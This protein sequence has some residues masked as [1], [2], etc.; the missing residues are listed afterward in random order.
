MKTFVAIIFGVLLPLSF[1]AFAEQGKDGVE[2]ENLRCESPDENN[3]GLQSYEPNIVGWNKDEH[4]D[5]HLDFKLSVKYPMRDYVSPAEGDS[6]WK[7]IYPYFAFTGR[8][9][10]YIGSQ[11]SSPVV[12]RRFN[13]ELF[14]RLWQRDGGVYKG[15]YLDVAY[16]HESN[17]QSINSEPEYDAKK[18]SLSNDRNDSRFADKFISRGWDYL[19]LT[20]KTCEPIAD[21]KKLSIYTQLRYFLDDGVFQGEAEEYFAFE[22]AG[23][24]RER[25]SYDGLSVL[26]RS[27]SDLFGRP[28]KFAMKLTTGYQD[29]FENN[30]LRLEATRKISIFPLTMWVQSGYNSDLVDYYERSTSYGIGFEFE[31]KL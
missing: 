9:S 26:F 2:R 6:I 16:G 20:W 23:E 15:G 17:G 29:V 5:S 25:A 8:F 10:Q 28:T 3:A 18:L 27:D 24:A 11:D 31:S 12:G 19:G 1:T 21:F 7:G 30:T 13:P 22:D 4:F 14:L